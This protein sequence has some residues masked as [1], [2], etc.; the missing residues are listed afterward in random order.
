MMLPLSALII[1]ATVA[2]F[3]TGT[4]IFAIYFT[5]KTR[6]EARRLRDAEAEQELRTPLRET[7]AEPGLDPRN[8]TPLP[9]QPPTP[10]AESPP[11]LLDDPD[12]RTTGAGTA[13]SVRAGTLPPFLL[14]ATTFHAKPPPPRSSP[15]PPTLEAD[16]PPPLPQD[17]LARASSP[18]PPHSPLLP[19]PISLPAP[20]KGPPKVRSRSRGGNPGPRPPYPTDTD[21]PD[22]MHEIYDIYSKLPPTPKT[23]PKSAPS[24]VTTFAQ[25]ESKWSYFGQK[26]AESQGKGSEYDVSVTTC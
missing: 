18:L 21:R 5:T 10:E 2:V 19:P 9:P 14:P 20:I 16:S 24:M 26:R 1:L 25:A 7:A 11:P 8:A 13:G 12:D 17:F 4:F 3:A 6:L 23:M 22:S 15:R